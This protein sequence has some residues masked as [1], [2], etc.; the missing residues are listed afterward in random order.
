MISLQAQDQQ[1]GYDILGQLLSVAQNY[2]IKCQEKSM[3]PK[4]HTIQ[5]MILFIML[6]KNPKKLPEESLLTQSI[7]FKLL[8][9]ISLTNIICLVT[10]KFSRINK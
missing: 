3:T 7:F 10:I 5:I 8:I 1:L 2:Y 6:I 9:N 4:Q